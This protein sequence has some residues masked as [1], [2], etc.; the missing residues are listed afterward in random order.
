MTVHENV[1]SLKQ[2]TANLLGH[3]LGI[4]EKKYILYDNQ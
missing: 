4:A 3:T 1:P 2:K